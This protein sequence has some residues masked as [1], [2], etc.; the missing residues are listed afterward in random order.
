MVV[1][2]SQ[3]VCTSPIAD[4]NGFHDLIMSH[5]SNNHA[6]L[7]YKRA[8]KLDTK[9]CKEK[10]IAAEKTHTHAAICLFA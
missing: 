9:F 3:I 6:H 10:M 7:I 8:K 1:K 4:I 5:F 2:N